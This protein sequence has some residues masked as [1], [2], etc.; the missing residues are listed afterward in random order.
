M[1]QGNNQY[2]PMCIVLYEENNSQEVKNLLNTHMVKKNRTD[3]DKQLAETIMGLLNKISDKN[4]NDI[5]SQLLK[6]VDRGQ[7]PAPERSVE[8]RLLYQAER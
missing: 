5:L 4:F 8:F 1:I 6:H 2:Y 7:G 3:D